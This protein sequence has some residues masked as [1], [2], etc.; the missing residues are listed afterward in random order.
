MITLEFLDSI[1]SNHKFFKDLHK[2]NAP[3]I[4]DKDIVQTAHEQQSTLLP[5]NTVSSNVQRDLY[6]QEF[7][8]MENNPNKQKVDG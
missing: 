7:A 2:I 3:A 8:T 1:S 6:K 4:N 5:L